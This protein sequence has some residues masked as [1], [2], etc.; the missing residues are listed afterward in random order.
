MYDA[1]QSSTSMDEGGPA[2]LSYGVGLVV[3]EE[4]SDDV[5]LG[6]YEVDNIASLRF[7]N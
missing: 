1:G 7:M 3:G 6:G 5:V 4:Y 2:V